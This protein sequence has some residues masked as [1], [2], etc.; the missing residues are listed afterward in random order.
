MMF[1]SEL[2]NSFNLLLKNMLIDNQTSISI[3]KS[4]LKTGAAKTKSDIHQVN[5]L[6][7]KSNFEYELGIGLFSISIMINIAPLKFYHEKNYSCF[8]VAFIKCECV[9][10]EKDF[11]NIIL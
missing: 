7:K 3:N 10:T 8:I 2:S 5:F 1:Y 4:T 11:T 9:C 6:S